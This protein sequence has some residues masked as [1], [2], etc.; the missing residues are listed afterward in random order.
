M[1]PEF[2]RASELFGLDDFSARDQ[3]G[4]A[5]EDIKHV[6]EDLGAVVRRLRCD[7]ETRAWC[8]GEDISPGFRWRRPFLRS[9]A[10]AGVSRA[11]A[12]RRQSNDRISFL[13]KTLLL[14]MRTK[15]AAI[16][17]PPNS[18]GK[19]L[20]MISS[21]RG[22]FRCSFKLCQVARTFKHREKHR[23]RQLA[24]IGVL[25]GRMIAG[26]GGQSAGQRVFGP[27]GKR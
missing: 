27:M 10:A 4:V 16:Q 13:V 23:A 14:H 7:C 12:N 8:S 20:F 22:G 3:R 26:D 1:P 18:L 24:G 5:I 21:S 17:L 25:Q 9:R 19:S 6:G 15:A 11:P 2:L